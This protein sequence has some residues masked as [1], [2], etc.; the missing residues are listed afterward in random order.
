MYAIIN[1]GRSH[2]KGQTDTILKL[3]VKFTDSE[4]LLIFIRLRD[5]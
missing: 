4:R 5:V 1:L 2:I 3:V